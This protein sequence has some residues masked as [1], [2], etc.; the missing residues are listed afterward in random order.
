M[1]VSKG[2]LGDAAHVTFQW[3][4]RPMPAF[5]GDTVASAL[6][7]QGIRLMGRSFKYHRPRGPLSA[8]PEEPNAL[9]SADG[10]PNTRATVQE[11]YEGLDA[12][13]QNAWPSLA[14]DALAVND[15][16]S[17]F[18]GAGFYYKTFMWP[19]RFWESLYEPLIRRAAGLGRLPRTYD[20]E[21][22]EK[23]WA[24]CDLLVIGGGPAGLMAALTAARAGA[25][26]ILADEGSRLGG[27]LLAEAEAVDGAPAHLW[28]G[29]AAAELAGLPNVR[30]LTRTTVTGA[31][32]GGTYGAL[33]RV[34]LHRPAGGD[35]PREC[36]WRIVAKRAV[37]AS[38]AIERPMLFPGNDRP[39]VMLAGAVRAYLHRWGVAAGQRVVVYGCSDDAHRTARDLHAAGVTVAMVVDQRPEARVVE[40]AAWPVLAGGR[41]TATRGRLGLGAVT[42][43]GPGGPRS[44]EADCLA[45]GGGWTPTIHLT[46]HLGARPL[47]DEA[48]QAFLAREGAVPGLGVAGAAAGLTSTA[49]VLRDGAEK[50][51]AALSDLGLRGSIDVPL[52]DEE[53]GAWGPV[54]AVEGRK[55]F[56]DFQNDVSVKDVRAAVAEGF[57]APEHLKRYTTLGM[58][59]D[60]GKTAN[61]AAL[62]VLAE[63]VGAPMGQAG[64]T[65]FRP[66]YTP[67]S[68]AAYG[69]GGEGMGFA[70]VRLTTSHEAALSRGAPMTEAGLWYRP[71]TFPRASDKGWRDACDRE[72]RLVREA[73]GVCDVS[74]LGKIDVQGADA[75]AFLDFV[76][77]GTMSTLPV[78]KVRYG[79]ML[80]EDGF[81]LDDGTCA[82]LGP[83][84]FVVTTTTAAAGPVMR[85]LDFAAQVLRPDLDVS[86]CSVT[87][88]WAQ[89]SVA[90]P[91][92]RELIESVVDVDV[93]D[94][95]LPFMGFREAE[96]AGIPG[97]LFRISFSGERAY[98]VAVPARWGAALYRLLVAQAEA[99]GGGAYG[100]EALNVLRIEKG[101]IT[102][103]EIHGRTTAADVG[104]GKLVSQKKDCIG[105]AMAHR[106]GLLDGDR[107]VLVGLRP[108]EPAGVVTAG[109]HL[110]GRD[111]PAVSAEDQGYVTSACW[112]PT[113]GTNL[114]LGFLRRGRERHG[115]VVRLVDA[116]R[117]VETMV[118][119]TDP[120][121]FDP[122]GGRVR[123]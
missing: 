91:R 71:L 67:V 98:E 15:A 84:H 102:H 14:F 81:V 32:D 34:G 6:L 11:A 7:A 116:M 99:L 69:A 80:R 46:S 57:S 112:S 105:W 38:G 3:D 74:T 85:H 20:G 89:F 79:L 68:I 1:R 62:A 58:A 9:I 42:V 64:T 121:A 35:L 86:M 45:M 90:G 25:E 48:R 96:V 60:Q 33:E 111:A 93:S 88:Q 122:E 44:V 53:E 41:V 10:V 24:F 22:F 52:A 113:L 109:A 103:A 13:S 50:A 73:V 66:P 108:L 12:R 106:E 17:P 51:V 76:Y 97:R 82:R 107:E 18:L 101:L 63:A 110:F 78:G 55:V 118:T 5:Q 2:L 95:A 27:R 26:V 39:G 114:G 8:G 19:T 29:A 65:T 30:V 56:L 92:S 23:A 94:A 47:W 115:E 4:G 40:G 83:S 31:Y 120:V 49:A 16:L 104:L 59:T 119:V 70:P 87:E 43:D 117:G 100:L 21:P 54:V 28:A 37:L 72:V 36:F 75:A 77:A 61:V 123:G